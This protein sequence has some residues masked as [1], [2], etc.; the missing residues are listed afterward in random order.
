VSNLKKKPLS[1]SQLKTW[2]KCKKKYY[3]DYIKELRWPS[4]QSNF[5]L[6]QRVHKLMEFQ[7]RGLDCTPLVTAAEH[8]VQ[9]AWN[10]LIRHP[11]TH[12]P[13]LGSEW[14]FLIPIHLD[15]QNVW[16]EGRIDRISERNNDSKAQVIVIDWKTGTAVPKQPEADW[17]TQVYL[18]ATV[19]SAKELGLKSLT[20]E[21]VAFVYV[22]VKDQVREIEIP[23]SSMQHQAVKQRLEQ[24]LQAIAQEEDF[25]LPKFCPDKFC[26]YRAICGIS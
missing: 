8:N 4:D 15:E 23:Y 2:S 21:E 24:T 6:G 10:N 1:V 17:Q 11:I 20:P 3:Y 13:I 12:L 7:S 26:P 25:P 9:Q 18:Y 19:E 14:G 22:E 5:K 16:L